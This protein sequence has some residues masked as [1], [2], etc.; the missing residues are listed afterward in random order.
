MEPLDLLIAH[1]RVVDPQNHRDAALNIGIAAGRIAYVGTELPTAQTVID[2][3]G[4]IVAPGFIDLHSHAQD[5]A[6]HRLQALDGV[7]TSL[8]LEGGATPVAASYAWSQSEGRPLHYGYSAGWLYARA[9]IKEQ[10]DD[11]AIAALP[12]LP[13]EAFSALQQGTAWA[14]PATAEELPRI[15]DLVEAQLDAGALGI[16]VLLGYAPRTE[17]EELRALGELATRRSVPLFVHIRWGAR[18]PGHTPVEAIEELIALSRQ[19][20]AR[21]HICHFASSNASTVEASSRALLA[22]QDE[23]L[24]VT[25]E[26]YPFGLASTVIGAEFLAPESLEAAGAPA[27]IV[28]YLKTGENISS[29]QRLAELR[30]ADPGGLCVIRY[31]D[32]A[33]PDQLDDLTQ[34]LSLPG[35]AFASDAMVVQQLAENTNGAPADVTQWPLPDHG[36]TVHPRTTSCF[37]RAIAWLHRDTAT[38]SLSDVIERSTAIPA[39]I[40]ADAVPPMRDK[41]HL[42]PGADA[43]VVVFDLN[44]LRPNTSFVPV[45]PSA[46]VDHVLVAGTPVVSHGALQPEHRP[47][48]PVYTTASTHTR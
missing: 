8:E 31:Y 23:G 4:K 12:S 29:Y 18:V 28:T 24:P 6:G 22:A 5:L 10:L 38:L 21:V 48:E 32:E 39:R 42:G 47:G 19:T 16:G 7:T 37:V 34:A 17:P 3:T 26:S 14:E 44:A 35:A 45:T 46:G 20:G 15:I 36:L 33:E 9:I 2:A 43:D 30:A 27:H 40:L 11:A 13:L 41:G 25:T 1:G